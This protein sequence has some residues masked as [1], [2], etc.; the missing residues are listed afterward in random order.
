M[1]D[2]DS[3]DTLEKDADIYAVI[4]DDEVAALRQ[5]ATDFFQKTDQIQQLRAA[6]NVG[7]D[8][9][10]NALALQLRDAFQMRDETIK[11]LE[12]K[13]DQ[14]EL[15]RTELAS[16]ISR[17][18]E[19]RHKIYVDEINRNRSLLEMADGQRNTIWNRLGTLQSKVDENVQKM[20]EKIGQY[21]EAVNTLRQDV[22]AITLKT[23]SE[24]EKINRD[25]LDLR[26]LEDVDN[27]LMYLDDPGNAGIPTLPDDNLLPT[28]PDS[29]FASTFG[30]G[31]N[32]R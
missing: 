10:F 15:K 26:R 12:Q 22:N 8:S 7:V 6:L 25:L 4:D 21:S 11:Q 28:L 31:H 5:D 29:L 14:S 19:M 23:E 1:S 17:S 32:I 2:T 16:R 3:E 13:L 18:I 24:L 20:E 30:L 27:V 9:R